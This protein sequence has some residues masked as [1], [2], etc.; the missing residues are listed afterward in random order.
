MKKHSNIK[1]YENPSSGSRTDMT[2]LIPAFRNFSNAHKIESKGNPM[3]DKK[4]CER[5]E[6]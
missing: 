4:A 5:V 1:L 3:H 2:Q 6:V